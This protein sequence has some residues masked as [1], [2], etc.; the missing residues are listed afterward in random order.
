MTPPRASSVSSGRVMPTASSGPKNHTTSPSSST[1]AASSASGCARCG[2]RRSSWQPR[3]PEQHDLRAAIAFASVGR[4]V[5]RQRV[6]VS[7]A[8]GAAPGDRWEAARP[9]PWPPPRRA[10][11]TAASWRGTEPCGSAG[12]RC[13]RSPARC[14]ARR[15]PPGRSGS[16]A[17]WQLGFSSAEPEANMVRLTSRTVTDCGSSSTCTRPAAISGCRNWCSD[18][19]GRVRARD[20]RGGRRGWRR[21]HRGGARDLDGTV[22]R[23]CGELAEGDVRRIGQQRG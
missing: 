10:P 22:R 6:G 11:A 5:G 2:H 18:G 7:L 4:G 15:A 20:G 14:P 19:P 23:Q 12:C 13:S 8:R 16:A 3:C 1:R 21:C 17:A 9:A